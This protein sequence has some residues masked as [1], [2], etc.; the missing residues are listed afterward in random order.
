MDNVGSVV[1]VKGVSMQP[2]LNPDLMH[3]DY[4]WLNKW[5]AKDFQFQRGNIVTL[6]AP[7][8]PRCTIIKRIVAI[9]GDTV[10]PNRRTEECIRIPAGHCWLEG[11]NVTMSKDSN[12]FGPV[13]VGLIEAKATYIVWPPQRWR[14]LNGYFNIPDRVVISGQLQQSHSV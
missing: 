7:Y 3:K 11:D 2:V 4:V 14:A 13:S 5:C 8:D 6:R 9:E 10:C 12:S 1:G